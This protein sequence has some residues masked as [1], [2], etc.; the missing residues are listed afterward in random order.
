MMMTVLVVDDDPAIAKLIAI[1]LA[2]EHIDVER[3]D[4]GEAALALLVDGRQQPDV[5]VL[6]LAMPGMDGRQVFREAR[7]AGVTSPIIF[8]S[9]Y[10]ASA[11]SNEL[12]AEGAIDKP[13]NPELLI[14]S[15]QAV[16]AGVR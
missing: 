15:I 12:G 10:G 13:F 6:D 8:C 2:T 3:A 11:A 7:R 5:I 4:S 16:A 9:A 1:I 14:A